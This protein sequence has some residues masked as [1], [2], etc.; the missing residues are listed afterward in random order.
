M[1]TI[2]LL[3]ATILSSHPSHAGHTM[4]HEMQ[5]GFVLAADDKFASHLVATKHHSWQTEIL[6]QL[7][8][9]DA[10][11]ASVYSER[12]AANTEGGAYFLFQA[13][14]LDLPSLKAGQILTGHIVESKVGKYEPKNII[15]RRATYKVET[16]LLSIE[17]PFFG[18]Q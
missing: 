9:E 13:Q 12:K 7:T 2:I 8:I 17:N 16:V 15:V 14:S 1:K 3:L 5:H 6:G 4:T 10:D 18:D 11:E